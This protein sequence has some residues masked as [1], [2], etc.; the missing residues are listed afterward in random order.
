[1]RLLPVVATFLSILACAGSSSTVVVE[2]TPPILSEA[3]TPKPVP[4]VASTPEGLVP[5]TFTLLMK[6]AGDLDLD[7]D[8]DAVLIL[9]AKADNEA[10]TRTVWLALQDDDGYRVAAKREGAVYCRTCG[11]V[12]G[13]PLS[14]VAIAK[15]RFSLEHYGGSNWRWTRII[16]FEHVDDHWEL[17]RDGGDS[18]HTSEP[19]KVTTSIKT[20][21]DF[22]TV[23][24][25]DF[26]ADP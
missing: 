22:G 6:Q 4:E 14:G 12:F 10:G 8:D 5:P 15:G 19:N 26:V 20:R 11:G 18:F 23:R 7:G 16:T 21:K 3:R 17:V 9:E 1:M 25:T 13:D 2:P 24:F